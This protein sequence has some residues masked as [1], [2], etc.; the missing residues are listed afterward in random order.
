MTFLKIPL[1]TLL[2]ASISLGAQVA[3]T[4]ALL[5]AVS[6]AEAGSTIE[7]TAG[8][9]ELSA[10]LVVKAGTT[11]K[12]AGVGKTII[13]HTSEWEA[14]PKSLPDPETNF[15]K[16]DK[17][18]YLIELQSKGDGITIS[19]LTLTGPQVHGGIYGWGNKNLHL[20][21]LHFEDFMFSGFRSYQTTHAKIHD[22][23][24]VDAGQRWAKGEPGLKGG[25]TGGGIFVIWIADSEIFNNRFLDT[26]KKKNLHYYGIKGRQGKRVRIH[27]NS[28][29][30][31]FSIEFA[32]ENDQDVEIDHNI[33][34]G[35]VSIPK[36]GGGSVPKGGKTFHIH[37]NYFTTSYAIEFPRNGAEIN[38]NLFDFDVKKDGGNL[39]SGFGGK[40]SP[41]PASFHNNLV[42]NPGRGVMWIERAYDGMEI[43]NNHIIARTT[44]EP[45][46]EGL[47]SFSGKSDFSTYVFRDNIVECEGTARPLFRNDESGKA[48]IANNKLVNIGDTARYENP[49]EDRKPG[50]EAPLKFRCGVDEEM[51]VDGWE[52][53]KPD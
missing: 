17:S 4:A 32:H 1:I 41:G 48:R 51:E 19:D 21:N 14:N 42:S 6:N 8:T 34:L 52:F 3:T 44:A 49:V 43:R 7:L 29:E 40:A 46:T 35:C 27:H 18:G 30:T 53:K 23:V 5:E 26:K 31:N 36:H 24:F 11:L 45:R 12:G 15:K 25:I 20:H 16:F 50:L 37:H 22:C 28:I 33:L 13:T 10:P 47:F 2:A 39:I 9:Y 38:N